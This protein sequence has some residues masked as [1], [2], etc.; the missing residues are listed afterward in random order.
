[1][2]SRV[3][4]K[5]LALA[6]FVAG[7]LDA[8]AVAALNS[9]NPC[10][11]NLTTASLLSS[12]FL[13]QA[14]TASGGV[15]LA[16]VRLPDHATDGSGPGVSSAAFCLANPE[17]YDVGVK[18][19]DA[20]RT[21]GHFWVFGTNLS[22]QTVMITVTDRMGGGTRIYKVGPLATGVDKTFPTGRTAALSGASSLPSLIA[23][24]IFSPFPVPAGVPVTFTDQSQGGPNSW[25]WAFG[26]ET[27]H[28]DCTSRDQ[29]PTHT[30]A[31]PGAYTI[32]L[33]ISRDDPVAVVTAS[34][35][36]PITVIA[37]SFH[38]TPS[39]SPGLLKFGRRLHSRRHGGG[40]W[41]GR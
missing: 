40:L 9:T 7:M 35:T 5:I 31:N 27:A 29:N 38:L 4:P 23:G 13:V 12:R 41:L 30:Y 16:S 11:P 3:L 21:S 36:W 22:G 6:V 8:L 24:F 37:C 17:S 2:T 10:D 28:G 15:R 1:M 33:D 34:L 32:Q 26:D 39:P 14:A 18:V 25:C 20:T 19:L